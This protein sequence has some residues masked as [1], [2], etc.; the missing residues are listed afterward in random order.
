VRL[1]L[2]GFRANDF[3]PGPLSEGDALARKSPFTGTFNADTRWQI[4]PAVSAFAEASV[5]DTRLS[6]QE[7]PGTFGT[8]TLL[9]SSI[10]LG[11]S[12]DTAVGLLSLSAE[13]SDVRDDIYNIGFDFIP[14]TVGEYQTTYVLQASD[15]MKLGADNTLRFGL[16]YRYDAENSGDLVYGT[17]SDAIASASLMWDWQIAPSL[18]LTNAIRIDDLN[19]HYAGTL[20]AETGVTA[21]EY[22]HTSMAVPSFN[23]GLVWK[24]TDDDT[25]RLTAARGVQLPTLLQYGLQVAPGFY[26]PVAY[27]GQ[28]DL[29]PSVIWNTELD[30]DRALPA[31]ASTL[32]TALFAQR[33]DNLI[34]WPFGA[35]LTFVP[36]GVPVFFSQNV[37]YSTA[38]GL[39]AGIKGHSA[40]GFRWNA[41]Y[42]LVSTTDHTSLN[43]GP[44]PTGIVNYDHSAPNHVVIGGLGYSAD[45]WEL[46]LMGR[47]QSSFLDY[48]LDPTRTMLLAENVDNYV[49][50]NARI[51]YRVTEHV[52]VAL[53]AQ[54]FNAANLAETAGP[55]VQRQ[56]ILSL[57][58][59]M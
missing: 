56:I 49:T 34:S 3:A 10:R 22:D 52:T 29:R 23:S 38:A 32:R 57:T 2:G 21:A 30:Y 28:P 39:E 14:V 13:R 15:L 44:A 36:P 47:W 11:V 59:H 41:S 9:T 46:D 42:A 54:Q 24:V 45:K 51:G 27:A 20:L 18:S 37:G 7:P 4:T 33:I 26:G 35:P 8:E 17:I 25:L 16:E 50:M 43:T 6:E 40:N 5:G 31:I 53:T 19:L 1:S 58:A 55:P 48:R 12:A